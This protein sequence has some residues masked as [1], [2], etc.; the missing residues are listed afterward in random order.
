[1]VWVYYKKAF[2]T[3][4]HELI[5]I[6]LKVL[7]VQPDIARCIENLLPLW[8]T[9][10]ILTSGKRGVSTEFVCYHRGVYKVTA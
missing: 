1:M 6:S 10:F 2:D 9:R 5:L 7:K 3:T 8:K 4:S